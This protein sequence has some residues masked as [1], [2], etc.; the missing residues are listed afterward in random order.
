MNV[1][2]CWSANTGVPMCRIS[3]ENITYEFIFTSPAVLSMSCSSCFDGLSDGNQVAIQ[4]LFC[5][6]LL[7][8]FVQNS[9]QHFCVVPFRFLSKHFVKAPVV[10]PYSSTDMGRIPNLFVRIRFPCC[11]FFPMHMLA[12]L[13]V[14][15]ILLP[16]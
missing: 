15:E 9:T 14:V 8:G 10:Q 12:M 7:P 13:S 16:R 3:L 11:S 5:R 2:F 6:V 1:S 4:L